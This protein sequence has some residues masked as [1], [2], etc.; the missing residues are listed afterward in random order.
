MVS[1]TAVYGRLVPS[2]WPVVMKKIAEVGAQCLEL[3]LHGR[4]R[5]RQKELRQG[6]VLGNFPSDLDPIMSQ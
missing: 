5:E 1:E 2:L 6:M 4:S 3:L